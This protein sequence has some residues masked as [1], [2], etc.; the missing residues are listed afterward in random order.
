MTYTGA[1]VIY[2][3]DEVGMGNYTGLPKDPGNRAA[4]E[5]S[6]V[7]QPDGKTFHNPY[8]DSISAL[9]RDLIRVRLNHPALRTPQIATLYRNNTDAT[10]AYARKSSGETVI[11]A[12]NDSASPKSLTIP[13]YGL[14][15]NGTVLRDE[16]SGNSYTVSSGSVTL[17]SLDGHFGAILATSPVLAKA[18]VTF[19]VNGYVT[20]YGQN[21]YVVGSA[22]ELGSWNTNNAVPLNWVDSDSWAGL[23][24]FTTSTGTTVQYKYI[25]KNPDG[26]IVWESDPNNSYTVP[27]RGDRFVTDTW[28]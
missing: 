20:T 4:M 23:A 10:Y 9:Y 15:A 7:V 24:T 2:Y 6:D 27:S 28:R 13:L 5:W 12:L 11:V 26:S 14:F 21:I 22:P 8:H 1:P 18:H 17:S 16:L 19:Q 25:V 3:G